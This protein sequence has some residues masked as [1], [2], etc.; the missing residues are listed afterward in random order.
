MSD[1]SLSSLASALGI[2]ADPRWA[3]RRAGSVVADSRH[4]RPGYIYV[5]ISGTKTD[6]ALYIDDALARGAA[7]VV[8]DHVPPNLAADACLLRVDNPRVALSRLAAAFYPRQPQHV[9]AVTGTDGKTST[10]DFFRQ[11]A[12]RLGHQAAAIGTLGLVGAHRAALGEGTHTTPDALSLH[13]MLQRLNDEGYTHVAMEAS[14]HGLDQHRLDSVRL[15][16]AAV[17]TIT[18]D[19]L[20]YHRTPE[21]YFA[22]KARL[23]NEVLPEGAAAVLNADDAS[24]HALHGLCAHRSMRIFS[25]GKAGSHLHVESITPVPLGQEVALTVFGVKHRL[26]VKLVGP[27]QVY[28]ILAALGLLAGAGMDVQ[29]AAELLP[30]LVSVPGRMQ[31]LGVHPHGASIYI[32]YAHT[33]GALATALRALRPH[34]HNR[35]VVVFG[36]GGNRDKGKRPE[37]GRIAAE[38]A[39]A[40]IVTDDNPRHE[41]PAA[42]RAEIL[43]GCPGAKA[44]ADRREAIYAALSMLLPGDV[45]LVAGKGHETTQIIGDTSYTFD[46]AAIIREAAGAS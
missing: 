22:A 1:L 15:Q 25:Y 41:D 6:G 37:M 34:T 27:F 8:A 9:V 14:S 11:F 10:A 21:A 45:L 24:F 28:N 39:D 38:L 36:C 44:I 3:Y 30:T 23:F 29:A 16:A 5:A 4:V 40:V 18:R 42:I 20:D 35:L 33:P 32:D 2:A 19:H 17:T 46:D 7:A 13:A 26:T 43:A 31:R 12:E